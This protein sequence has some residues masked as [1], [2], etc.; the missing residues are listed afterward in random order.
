[1]CSWS[2]IS[3]KQSGTD[4]D[5]DFER[6]LQYNDKEAMRPLDRSRNLSDSRQDIHS[7]GFD[8]HSVDRDTS[9][10]HSRG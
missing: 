6:G 3:R 4:D 2:N 7:I 10:V 1:M 5:K 9:D 8:T